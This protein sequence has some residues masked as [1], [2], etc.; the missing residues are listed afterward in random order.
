MQALVVHVFRV[1]MSFLNVFPNAL[2]DS[3]A[4]LD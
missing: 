4:A 3:L 1:E 2:L